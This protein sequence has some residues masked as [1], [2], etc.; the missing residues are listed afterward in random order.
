MAS[1]KIL[2][3]APVADCSSR[4]GHFFL[5]TFSLGQQ[6]KGH[7][8]AAADE[9]QRFHES[10]KFVREARVYK[11]LLHKTGSQQRRRLHK[12]KTA[13]KKKPRRSG[14]FRSTSRVR[15]EAV[16]QRQAEQV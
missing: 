11:P 12:A 16:L 10:T 9:D 1:T 2:R 3:V 8:A 6:R 14:A 7:S 15:S 5:V 13:H 4:G